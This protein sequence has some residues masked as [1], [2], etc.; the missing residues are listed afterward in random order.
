MDG[1]T[2]VVLAG[3]FGTRLR[4]LTNHLP[5]AMLPVLNRPFLEHL[6]ERLRVAG[7]GRVI[8]ALG[9]KAEP[10]VAHFG[11]G[12]GFGLRIEYEVETQPLGTSGAVRAL[13]PRL[14][15]TFLVLNGDCIAALDVGAMVHGHMER[16]EHA[17]LAT[18]RVDDPSRFGVVVT[19][20][21]GYVSQ[22]IEKPPGPRFPAYTINTGVY[23]LEPEML[24]FVP[25]G[26][27]S[28]F[29]R[30]LFPTAL[31]MGVQVHSFL[32]Q[33][34]FTDMGTPASYLDLNR[35][36]LLGRVP[37]PPG[38]SQVGA[39][40]GKDVSIDPTAKIEGPVLLG[41]GVQIGPNARI[42]GPV[43]VG[44]RCVV[45]AE[46]SIEG[47][48]LWEGARVGEKAVLRGAVLGR[49]VRIA[50]GAS[51]EPGAVLENGARFPA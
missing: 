3:G 34:Y 45:G 12:E 8:M 32:W 50:S 40:P 33:G 29:E 7:V 25:E 23:V 4:P 13:L 28:M 21:E 15:D 39:S 51:L 41:D 46:A 1:L 43:V 47:S 20:G 11:H 35:D 31:G 22:F 19:D 6:L 36:M 18:H 17:T 37:P 27:P 5:K 16:R 30:D 48:V 2:A 38:V 42:V 44:P 10:L 49:D 9:Y 14:H 24:R 26:K